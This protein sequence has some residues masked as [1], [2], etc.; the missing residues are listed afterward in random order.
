MRELNTCAGDPAVASALYHHGGDTGRGDADAAQRRVP[1]LAVLL[2]AVQTENPELASCIRA[3]AACG[4]LL[5]DSLL[6]GI[7]CGHGAS[8]RISPD[9]SSTPCTAV[10][11]GRARVEE[12]PQ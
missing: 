10:A 12:Q 3:S 8:R 11:N 2:V 1:N 5:A 9:D 6:M 7:C 4:L